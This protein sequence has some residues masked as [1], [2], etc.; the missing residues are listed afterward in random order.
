MASFLQIYEDKIR[1]T[2]KKQSVPVNWTT[3]SGVFNKNTWLIWSAIVITL[4]FFFTLF[5]RLAA[6]PTEKN[7]IHNWLLSGLV[8]ALSSSGDLFISEAIDKR[9]EPRRHFRVLLMTTSVFGVLIYN[10]YVSAIISNLI[11]KEK[12]TEIDSLDQV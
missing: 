4:T 8:I 2:Y 10:F 3:F 1:L 12:Y 7:L 11:T 5:S 9:L 6:P